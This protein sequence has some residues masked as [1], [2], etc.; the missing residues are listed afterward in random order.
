M[1]KQQ[2]KTADMTKKVH[3]CPHCNRP[4]I[5]S[6][7]KGYAWQ[8]LECEED[9][10]NIEVQEF[11]RVA[12]E[13][14]LMGLNKHN[15]YDGAHE[16]M[17]ASFKEEGDALAYAYE[18]AFS[19][20]KGCKAT[21][22]RVEFVGYDKDGASCIDVIYERAVEPNEAKKHKKKGGE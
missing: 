14:W 19:P 6:E 20:Y 5:P 22:V 13:V 7:I 9:F 17:Y 2:R 16:E 8:C 1:K 21:E 12:Y 4:L 11:D 15:M 18:R 10:Y 3:L